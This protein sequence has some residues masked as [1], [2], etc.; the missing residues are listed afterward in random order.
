MA[1]NYIISSGFSDF[2]SEDYPNPQP[3]F[4]AS[5]KI[6]E[7]PCKEVG[8]TS[9]LIR[10]S[11][12]HYWNAYT[13][14][15]HRFTVYIDGEEVGISPEIRYEAWMADIYGYNPGYATVSN[16]TVVTVPAKGGR[17]TVSFVSSSS[18]NEYA[19]DI[20]LHPLLS[21]TINKDEKLRNFALSI[22]GCN[23]EAAKTMTE[24]GFAYGSTEYS[25]EAAVEAGYELHPQSDSGIL[26]Q[27]LVIAPAVVPMATAELYNGEWTR[28]FFMLFSNGSWGMYQAQICSGGQWHRYY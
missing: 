2:V 24:S 27:S 3:Y 18:G 28:Y 19:F 22:G 9:F 26:T 4:T 12:Y 1:E 11:C 10:G 15:G 20:Y 13:G 14:I 6:E 7:T 17:H 25:W 21:I 23:F 5:V 8:K 16:S